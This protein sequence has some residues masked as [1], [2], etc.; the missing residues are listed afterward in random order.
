[1]AQSKVDILSKLN[2]QNIIKLFDSFIE[3]SFFNIVM[4]YLEG[5]TLGSF[6]SKQTNLLDEQFIL[7][8]FVQILSALQFCHQNNLLH[9]DIKPENIFLTNSGLVKLFDFGISKML[10]ANIQQAQTYAGT[11]NYM[12]TEV[13]EGKSYSYPTDVW[14]LGC[15]IYELATLHPLFE[16]TNLS[17][18]VQRITVLPIPNIPTN[19]SSSL[20]SIVQSMLNRDQIFRPSLEMI[21]KHPLIQNFK[22][23][24]NVQALTNK[25]QT[26]ESE[27][28]NLHLK[29]D[30]QN[31]AIQEL[32]LF[33]YQLEQLDH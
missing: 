16:S 26:L 15:V 25:V 30:S 23:K 8:T 1:M 31:K 12:S 20:S 17:N 4:E 33:K 3:G 24:E 18:L 13:I 5:E 2:H 32:A 10:T 27:I 21:Q 11:S 22:P 7:E 14:S 6:I 19:Y 29:L 28:H 9:R